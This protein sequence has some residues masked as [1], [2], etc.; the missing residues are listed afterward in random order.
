V[1]AHARQWTFIFLAFCWSSPANA[2]PSALVRLTTANWGKLAPKILAY[3]AVAADSAHMSTVALS[4][5][6][7]VDAVAVRAGQTVNKG[8]PILTIATA[9][10]AA[11]QYQQAASAASFAGK[12]LTHTRELFA[13]KLA[14]RSQLDAAEK[15]YSDAQTLLSQQTQIGTGNKDSVVQADAAGIV[16]TVTALPGDRIAAGTV[17]A[18]IATRNRM[19]LNLGLEPEDA[20]SVPVGAAVSLSS[21][22]NDALAFTSRVLS[23]NAMTDAQSRLVNAVVAVPDEI[24]PRLILG[25]TL[26]GIV[27]L[28]ARSGIVIPRACLLSDTAGTFVFTVKAGIAHRREV[29]VA[30]ETD[31]EALIGTGLAR[32][33]RVVDDGSAG[34]TDGMA[35]R[36]GN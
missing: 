8:D 27:S 6:G 9:P 15:A 4:S 26:V 20:S 14:T 28:P 30:L 1:T 10:G 16:V 13:E 5:D 36:T 3:G 34:L 31:D 22:R 7:V 35:V 32:G 2:D 25:T 29:R 17:V 33:E 19:I 11:A 24:A 21:P 12:D 23:V 18:T